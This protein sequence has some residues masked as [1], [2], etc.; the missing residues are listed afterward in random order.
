MITQKNNTSIL[1]RCNVRRRAHRR[2]CVFVNTQ[3]YTLFVILKSYGL[4][5][6]MRGV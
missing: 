4:D 6:K 2:V 1:I 5:T 3:N